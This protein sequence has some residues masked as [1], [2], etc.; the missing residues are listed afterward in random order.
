[1]R[2]L[3]KVTLAQDVGGK[4]RFGSGSA[5]VSGARLKSVHFGNLPPSSPFIR[6]CDVTREV[7]SDRVRQC[8]RE[9]DE[10]CSGFFFFF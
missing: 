3:I 9:F 4:K 5:T 8:G 10:I 7:G 6:C 1:M 2:G